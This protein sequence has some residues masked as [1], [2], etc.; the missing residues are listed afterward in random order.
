MNRIDQ[1]T[2]DT[3]RYL[4]ERD[5]AI[6]DLAART[7]AGYMREILGS[8]YNPGLPCFDQS[9]N[10]GIHPDEEDR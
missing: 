10:G 2:A 1:L 8:N 5:A 9:G 6:R 4:D 7:D 3:L